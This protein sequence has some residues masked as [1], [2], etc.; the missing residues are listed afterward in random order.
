MC[1]NIW[2]DVQVG[3]L[4]TAH[5]THSR[6]SKD[7]VILYP[8]ICKNY[9]DVMCL[10]LRAWRRNQAGTLAAFLQKQHSFEVWPGQWVLIPFQSAA[11]DLNDLPL[12]LNILPSAHSALSS[13]FTTAWK[14]CTNC[15]VRGKKGDL[16]L[17]GVLCCCDQ[18]DLCL[19]LL[20]VDSAPRCVL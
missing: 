14:Q 15:R 10:R 1:K 11:A 9:L 13:L 19:Q 17:S 16:L 5:S 20:S 4:Q 7:I 18:Y 6:F 3:P 8:T 2:T 12:T